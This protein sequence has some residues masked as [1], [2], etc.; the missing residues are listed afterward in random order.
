MTQAYEGRKP[1]SRNDEPSPRLAPGHP[2]EQAP[3][4]PALPTGQADPK[5]QEAARS[6]ATIYTGTGHYRFE[7]DRNNQNILVS[8][9]GQIVWRSNGLH[10]FHAI[11]QA[12]AI[13]RKEAVIAEAEAAAE[14]A[15]EEGAPRG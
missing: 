12:I 2:V 14:R 13:D 5:W 1:A 7:Q 10:A 11:L 4:R 9:R 6:F 8:P 15:E 3:I